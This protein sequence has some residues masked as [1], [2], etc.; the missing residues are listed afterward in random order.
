MGVYEGKKEKVEMLLDYNINLKIKGAIKIFYMY[1][2]YHD[3]KQVN[4]FC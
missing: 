2:Q 3:I 1:Y 4:Y